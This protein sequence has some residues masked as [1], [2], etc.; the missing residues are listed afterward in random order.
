MQ[1]PQSQKNGDAPE[2]QKVNLNILT[3]LQAIH[4]VSASQRSGQVTLG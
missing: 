1:I 3:G 4:P 2:H